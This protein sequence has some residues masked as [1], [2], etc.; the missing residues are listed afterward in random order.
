MNNGFINFNDPIAGSPTITLLRLFLS[1]IHSICKGLVNLPLTH[2]VYQSK[3][4]TGGVYKRQG[5]IRYTMLQCTY[6]GFLVQV[7]NCSKLSHS[8]LN[9]CD[10]HNL[11]DM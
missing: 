5:R 10:S 11:S 9:I 4:T 8:R 2:T 7:Y 3:E 1:P 6:K